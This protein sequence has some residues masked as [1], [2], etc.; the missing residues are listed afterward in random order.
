MQRRFPFGLPD[1]RPRLRVLD[2]RRDYLD[3]R[4]Q[5]APNRAY[6]DHNWGCLQRVVEELGLV[7]S[8]PLYDARFGGLLRPDC[9]VLGFC[10]AERR[11]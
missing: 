6:C 3:L 2:N 5:L 8:A 7:H 4:D 1:S 11:D 9:G 10:E